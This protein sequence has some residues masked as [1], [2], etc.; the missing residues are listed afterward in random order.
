MAAEP[1]VITAGIE[2]YIAWCDSLLAAISCAA[3]SAAFL[4]CRAQLGDA[5]EALN[6]SR[7]RAKEAD[8]KLPA[9]R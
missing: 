8:E 3:Q 4:I 2:T 5:D 6:S 9:V 7:G 1:S